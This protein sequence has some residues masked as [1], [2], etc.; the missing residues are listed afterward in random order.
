LPLSSQT[1]AAFC[2]HWTATISSSRWPPS[3]LHPHHLS[4]L[5]HLRLL[6]PEVVAS[7]PQLHFCPSGSPERVWPSLL[8]LPPPHRLDSTSSWGRPPRCRSRDW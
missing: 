3:H 7:S 5:H 6:T 4:L 8:L 2:L 1:S